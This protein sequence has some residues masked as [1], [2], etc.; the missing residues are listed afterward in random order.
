V[1][2][3]DEHRHDLVQGV[4]G[5]EFG[6]EPICRVLSE[7]GC[8][9]APGTY[10]AA[11]KRPPCARVV[12]DEELVV[13]IRRV[14]GENY[15]VYGARKVWK[16]LHREGTPVARCTVERL[17][18]VEGLA[19]AI[20]GATTRTTKADPAAARPEDLV[21][22]KFNA[23]RPDELWVVDFTCGAALCG[24]RRAGSDLIGA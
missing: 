20:R 21:D 3:I 2:F 16:Q 1:K 10:R 7:H 17:M 9:V 19:G 13:E 14:H 22:R 5:R 15:G 4:V 24:A 6:V 8:Q 18:R 11:A 23:Q 12:R